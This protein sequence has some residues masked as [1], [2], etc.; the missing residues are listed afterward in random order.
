MQEAVVEEEQQEDQPT[1]QLI[2]RLEGGSISANDIKKLRD[3]GYFTVDSV[4]Q[5]TKKDLGLIKGI[6]EQKVEKLQ[7]AAFKMTQMGFTT[8]TE[9]HQQRQDICFLT[10]GAKELDGLLGGGMET[11]SITE[12]F[13][14]FRTGKTQLCHT[15]CV[16][17]QLPLEQGG[18]EGKAMYIDT[19]GTFRPQRLLEIAEKYGLDGQDVLDNVSAQRARSTQRTAQPSERRASAHTS[20]TPTPRP[21]PRPQVSYARAYNSEH[22]LQLLVQASCMM[23][24]GRYG[25][26]IVDSCTGL[27]RTDYS[28]RGEL[29][30]RQMHLAKFLRALS[31]LASQYGIA[32]V[33][34]NQVVAQV[35]G[36][37]GDAK[38]PIGGNIIA[39]ASTTRLYLRKGR[40]ENRICK[41][42]DSPCL[43]EGEATFS[44][45]GSGIGDAQD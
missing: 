6:S 3:G 1:C 34:T 8:A 17:S 24:E 20:P 10:T 36:G 27:Y 33:I 9:V 30:A 4:A 14:E 44:I 43:P 11:G 16:T 2:E 40:G 19:E 42:Y 5:A 32:C 23:S 7:E 38:K 12:I 29:S 26:L 21:P 41:V 28:G 39:H 15:L 31:R 22:Q 37:I 13:G 45:Q 25:L 35:D 18:C